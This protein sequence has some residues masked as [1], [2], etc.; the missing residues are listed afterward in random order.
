MD[1]SVEWNWVLLAYSL[2][3]GALAVFTTSI[4][5]R[6]SRARRKLVEHS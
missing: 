6:I 5:L 4:A 3:Y 2:A 1:P